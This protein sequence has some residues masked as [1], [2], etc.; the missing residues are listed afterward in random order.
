MRI[1]SVHIQG[2]HNVEDKTYHLSN[3][4]YFYGENGAGKSTVLQA[5]QLALLGYIP[6]YNKTKE[7]IF[8]HANCSKM[9]VELTLDDDTTIMRS[10]QRKGRDI[11]TESSV[12]DTSDLLGSIELPISNFSEFTSMTAN[13][14]K[15]WFI[16]FLPDADK[17]IDWYECM[18]MAVT[19]M[20]LT[21]DSNNYLNDIETYANT[22]SGSSVQ[23][24]R[25]LNTYLKGQVSFT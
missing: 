14:L 18:H 19:D 13:K 7:G 11:V 16:S 10:W 20:K 15:D 4:T 6:G 1:K 25:D 21:A 2:M 3:A 24:V 17:A 22:L 5:I 12:D 23:I 9:V 8:R